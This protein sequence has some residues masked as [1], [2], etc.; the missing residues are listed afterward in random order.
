MG[1]GFLISKGPCLDCPYDCLQSVSSR[2]TALFCCGI[3]FSSRPERCLSHLC[4]PFL[5]MYAT[6]Y[7]AD[8]SVAS[9]FFLC[10]SQLFW[11]YVPVALFL[12]CTCSVPV[13]LPKHQVTQYTWHSYVLIVENDAFFCVLLIYVVY[14]VYV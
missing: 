3:L 11:L 10:T 5:I 1:T 4:I 2:D 14:F 7:Y 13:V 9:L 6:F 12:C 8:Y